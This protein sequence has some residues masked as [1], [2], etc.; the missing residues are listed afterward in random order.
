MK[1]FTEKISNVSELLEAVL[2]FRV[3]KTLFAAVELRLFDWLAE[4]PLSANELAG[5]IGIGAETLARILDACAGLGLLE[6]NG[7]KYENTALAEDYLRWSSDASLNLILERY[8][9]IEYEAWRHLETAISGYCPPLPTQAA[10]DEA[11]VSFHVRMN[12]YIRL[13]MPDF[14]EKFDLSRFTNAVDLG[15]GTGGF[16]IAVAEA[17]PQMQATVFDKILENETVL[18]YAHEFL[19]KSAVQDKSKVEFLSGDYLKDEFPPGD[20]LV[21]SRA[22]HHHSGKEIEKIMQCVFDVLP[23]GGAFLIAEHLLNDDKNGS[24]RALLQGVNMLLWSDQYKQ[25]SFGEYL[26]IA[27]KTGFVEELR[28]QAGGSGLDGLLLKKS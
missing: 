19:E 3:S 25:R 26:A 7:G 21:A 15:G 12:N 16:I 6:K 17:N 24:L 2:A 23:S 13:V 4:K 8:N 10:S 27:E 9:K 22:L 5:K 18:N 14:L 20:L 1:I 11:R 28:F